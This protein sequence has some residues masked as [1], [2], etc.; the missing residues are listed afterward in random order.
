[1][2]FTNSA[3]ELL[4]EREQDAPLVEALI[5]RAFGPGRFVKTAERLREGNRPLADLSFA[6]WW[7][8]RAVG[9]V[10]LWPIRIGDT[11]ALLLGPFA[12]EEEFRGQ[13]LGAALIVRACEAAASAGH[14]WMLLVGDAEFFVPL[15]FSRA[16][17]VTLPGPVDTRR[18]LLR[19][20]SDGTDA[21]PT[22][23]VSVPD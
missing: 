19:P 6:A 17:G 18:V 8:G 21:T 13:G 16:A 14:Q 7:D 20:L 10:R 22:G 9:C 12:V 2:T 23:L 1:M 4:P 11:P 5:A 15:G 3:P